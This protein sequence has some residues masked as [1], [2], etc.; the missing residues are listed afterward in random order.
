MS[1]SDPLVRKALLRQLQ[2]K[3]LEKDAASNAEGLFLKLIS[4]EERPI[5]SNVLSRL[6]LNEAHLHCF[7]GD[8]MLLARQLGEAKRGNDGARVAVM[9]A[10]RLA[11]NGEKERAEEAF[12]LAFHLDRTNPDAANGLLDVAKQVIKP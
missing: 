9:L 10:R 3:I 7:K 11:C 12:L 2:C 1:S 6:A 8:F 4:E 5:S